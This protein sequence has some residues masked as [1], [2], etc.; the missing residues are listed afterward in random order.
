MQRHYAQLQQ[1][2]PPAGAATVT[3]AQA[4]PR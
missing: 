1:A 3:A 4:E 2:A